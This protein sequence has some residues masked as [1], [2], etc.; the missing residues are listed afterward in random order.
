MILINWLGL[1][2]MAKV[3]ASLNHNV[4]NS[5]PPVRAAG[6]ARLGVLR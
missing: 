5:V 1:S 2:G 4:P 6:L 3:L